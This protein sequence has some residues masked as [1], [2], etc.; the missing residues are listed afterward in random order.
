MFGTPN[1]GFFLASLLRALLGGGA[2]AGYDMST[3]RE[4]GDRYRG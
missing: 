3:G 2:R 4:L 1:L